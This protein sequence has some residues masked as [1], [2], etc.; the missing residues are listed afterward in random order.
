MKSSVPSKSLGGFTLMEV[1]ISV[2][3]FSLLFSFTAMGAS[4][5]SK[6]LLIGPSDA[7][8]ENILITASRRARDGVEASDW[9]VNLPYD[10][11][12]RTLASITVFKGSSYAARDS[13]FDQTFTYSDN[14]DFVT[15]DFSGSLPAT[16][17]DHEIVFE[18][19]S[20]ET[21]MFGSVVLEVFGVERS[22]A[23]SSQG[24][25]TREL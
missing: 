4:Q 17:N 19:Y 24:M 9:G 20:G 10:E 13:S 3:I 8:L 5:L 14:I 22:V 2:A 21:A 25:I 1:L 23:I 6:R 18:R 7:Y 16:G 15:V 12:T 11:Q